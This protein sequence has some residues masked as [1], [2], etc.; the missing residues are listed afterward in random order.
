MLSD[1]LKNWIAQKSCKMPKNEATKER[2]RITKCRVS[3][4]FFPSAVICCWYWTSATDSDDHHLFFSFCFTCRHDNYLWLAQKGGVEL[5]CCWWLAFLPRFIFRLRLP[6]LCWLCF[7][8]ASTQTS[9][10][11]QQEQTRRP[12]KQIKYYWKEFANLN[13]LYLIH[14]FLSFTLHMQNRKTNLIFLFSFFFF[15]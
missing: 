7:T 8:R 2:D 13:L 5:C 6:P 11:S 9:L 15:M 4:F 14:F 3:A 12:Q 1:E 10:S